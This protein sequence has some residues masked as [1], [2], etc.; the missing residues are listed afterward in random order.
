VTHRKD[1][2]LLDGSRSRD[3]LSYRQGNREATKKRSVPKAADVPI[4]FRINVEVDNLA[5]AATFSHRT[6]AP[7]VVARWER[8]RPPAHADEGRKGVALARK[9]T[10]KPSSLV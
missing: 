5:R 3:P 8:G 4:P 10:Q 2:L 1:R 7:P 9:E 6:L